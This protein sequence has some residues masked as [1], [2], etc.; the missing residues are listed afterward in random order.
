MAEQCSSRQGSRLNT[1]ESAQSK[2]WVQHR[3]VRSPILPRD[4]FNVRHWTDKVPVS[5]AS[6]VVPEKGDNFLYMPD[7]LRYGRV[8]LT[9]NW[10]TDGAGQGATS[11]TRYDARLRRIRNS[12]E[13]FTARAH[14]KEDKAD[15][16]IQ[17]RLD[18]I[19][20]TRYEWFNRQPGAW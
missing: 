2:P 17:G 6:I 15:M 1:G 13:A 7:W 18:G 5:T 16:A 11:K 14:A 20:K 4:H 9:S 12:Q 3:N 10:I 19:G 8:G